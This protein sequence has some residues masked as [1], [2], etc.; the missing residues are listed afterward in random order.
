VGASDDSATDRLVRTWLRY[1]RTGGD[2]RFWAIEFVSSLV[3]DSPEEAWA[4]VRRLIAGADTEELLCAVGAG[5]L[6]TLIRKHGERIF[7]SVA[8]AAR[9]DP[10]CRVA[11]SCVWADDPMRT[12]IEATLREAG[13]QQ[14]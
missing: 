7:D 12:R 10:K 2:T 5:P 9:A 11:L 6:E 1:Y 4:V 3:D 14:R 8:S 13:R